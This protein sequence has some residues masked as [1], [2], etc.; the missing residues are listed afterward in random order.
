MCSETLTDSVAFHRQQ[1][2]FVPHTFS[3]DFMVVAC[4]NSC[5]PSIMC[6]KLKSG[7]VCNILGMKGL[8]KFFFFS[9]TWFIFLSKTK[10]NSNFISVV[11][12]LL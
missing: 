10:A 12:S 8:N 1:G 11:S 2:D 9:S 5:I 6:E 7:V 4:H 3:T